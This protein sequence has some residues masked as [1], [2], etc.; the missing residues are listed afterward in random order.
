[1][2]RL[3]RAWQALEAWVAEREPV[4]WLALFRV[5]IGGV[6]AVDLI[7]TWSSGALQLLWLPPGAGGLDELAGD[8]RI[9]LLGGAEPA[10]VYAWFVAALLGCASLITGLG[11]R[12]GALVA[13]QALLALFSLAPG[14]GGGHDRLLTNALWLL[15]LAP[16][17]A[18]L[19]LGCR[20]RTGAWTDPTPRVAWPRRLLA[21]QLVVT[22][23]V[24]GWQKLGPEWWPWGGLEAVYRSLLQPSWARWDLAP[25]LGPLFPVTQAM[26][27]ATIAWEGSFPLLVA[28]WVGRRRGWRIG[29]WPVR[30]VLL[31]IGVVMHSM[32]WAT[33]NLGPF[34]FVTL[35][36][37][38]CCLDE[39]DWA[40]LRSGTTLTGG[41]GPRR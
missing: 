4:T 26:T 17:G 19:S 31:G 1:V 29:R 34:P 36:F 14:T 33:S 30:G 3:Q 2:I 11:S 12:V 20:L 6:V 25:V 22:Y 16:A 5:S 37:Y 21:W 38:L 27:A 10:A 7:D 39:R 18:S 23:T 9:R 13:G 40:A 28:W 35:A 15:V 41:I 24:T 32:L 8:W